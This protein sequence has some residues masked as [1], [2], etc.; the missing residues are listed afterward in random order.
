MKK[1]LITWD[2]ESVENT[3]DNMNFTII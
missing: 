1:I 2:Y 3:Y